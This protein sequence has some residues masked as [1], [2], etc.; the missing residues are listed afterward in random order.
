MSGIH[1]DVTQNYEDIQWMS[2]RDASGVVLDG[3]HVLT[4]LHAVSC[5]VIPDVA[6]AL[7]DGTHR[8]MYVVS[9]L[10]DKDIAILN[11]ASA[12]WFPGPPAPPI[13]SQNTLVNGETVCIETGYP[14]RQ[15]VC[16][17]I[18]TIGHGR[19]SVGVKTTAGNSGSPAYDEAGQLL[20]VL[21]GS[22]VGG[23]TLVERVHAEN[24][25]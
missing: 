14:K 8:R 2:D 1:S 19:F 21:L 15:R 6:V 3:L 17:P 18:L 20:G 12:D 22:T 13:I 4:A 24:L 25:R 11:M 7:P 23:N 10:E 9:E 16:G 5:P